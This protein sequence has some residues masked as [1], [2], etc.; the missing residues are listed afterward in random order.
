MEK[1]NICG[2]CDSEEHY[3]KKRIIETRRNGK[4]IHTE[5]IYEERCNECGN[6][7]F[8]YSKAIN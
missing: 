2:H 8:G 6:L 4:L 7:I 3:P 5:E 1:N